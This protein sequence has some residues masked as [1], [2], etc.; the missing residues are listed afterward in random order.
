MASNEYITISDVTNVMFARIGSLGTSAA[1][2][3][4]Q[5]YID[6]ANNE[7]ESL[8]QTYG[9]GG[10][11]IYTPISF[12]VKQ[13][14]INI[15]LYMFASDFVGAN[16]TPEVSE[17]DSYKILFD[18]SLYLVNRYKPEITKEMLTNTVNDKYDRSVSYG[19]TVRA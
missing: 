9:V 8:A 3:A 11:D 13:Y 6:E 19:R 5:T 12:T 10:D 1:T 18:R 17:F 16:Q 7:C 14:L 4:Q 2:D 15:C